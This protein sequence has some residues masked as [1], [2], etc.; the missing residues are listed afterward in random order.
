[1]I[2]FWLIAAGL[3]AIALLFIVPTLLGRSQGGESSTRRSEANLSIYRDQ[4]R[5]LDADLAAGKLEQEQYQEA[6]NEIEVRLLE[7]SAASD[8]EATPSSGRWLIIAAVVTVPLLTVTLYML[9]GKP[10]GL[11]PVPQAAETGPQAG[12]SQAQIE[13][14][15]A[16]LE[17]K[18]KAQP[19]DP[20]GWAMLGNSYAVLGRFKDSVAAY[21]QAARLEPNNAQLLADYADVLALTQ[22][23]TFQGEPE[24]LIERALNVDPKNVKALALAGSAAFQRK[25]YETAIDFWQRI[26]PLAPADSDLMRS[27]NNNIAQ[28]Q[29]LAGQ[30]AAATD[31][32]ASQNQT[33]PAGGGASVSGTVVLDPALKAQVA[34]T[35]TVFVFAHDADAQHGPP[36]AIMRKTVKDLPLSF[37]LDDSMTII[38]TMKLSSAARVV[39]GARISKSGNATPSPGDIQGFSQPVKIGQR[40]IN[41]K[42]ETVVK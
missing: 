32:A 28:A 17:K 39:V 41:I 33:H 27:I 20:K 25:N 40:G 14:M 38:P 7:D 8:E 30:S 13:A 1:M 10:E 42:I 16:G 29:K 22:G 19:D 18:L 35:A 4:L 2:T 24:A 5:E 21:G 26:A 9:L 37:T 34:D 6:R 36:L 15:V 12:V 31:A 23:K 11:K 3:I